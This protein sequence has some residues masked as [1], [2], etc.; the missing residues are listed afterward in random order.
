MR[1]FAALMLA[2][3]ADVTAA[4]VSEQ[5]EPIRAR[6][7][8]PA[9]AAASVAGGEILDAGACG[10]RKMDGTER[11]TLDD[12]WHL[13]SCTKSM[14]SS[15]AAMLVERGVLKWGTTLADVF[16]KMEMDTA[17][18]DV[19]LEQLLTHRAGAPHD[20][21][22]LLWAQACLRQGTPTDQRMAFVRG[23]VRT[24][25]EATPGTKF[26]YSNQGYSIAG[27]M[28]EQ[29]TGR[30]WE[31]L[32]RENLFGPLKLDS[33]GF[34]APG[35]ATVVDQ[36]WPHLGAGLKFGPVTPG[37]F[38]DNP[39]AIGP[40]G[41]VNLAIR[42]FA[43]YAAWHSGE[44]RRPGPL[45]VGSFTKL[46]TAAAGGDYAFGWAV[47]DRPWAGGRVLTH[48]G[49]NTMNF[50][51]MWVAPERDFAVVAAT[52]APG[53]EAGKGCDEAVGMLIRRW[54]AGHR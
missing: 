11:V 7:G 42:D 5:L 48:T 4:D 32:M 53:D 12:K 38:A 8:L 20:A 15:L 54:E 41:I 33:A 37:P 9:L 49:S 27:A 16:P 21:P 30:P 26:V 43:R 3:M 22:P 23:L 18:R 13:G 17:W 36:P 50:A 45:G 47:L 25:P 31:E 51:V 1:T 40:A 2:L 14:T 46:H 34:G 6:H 52:N 44:G 19:T 10:V 39:P 28:I 35:S 29:A 24:A